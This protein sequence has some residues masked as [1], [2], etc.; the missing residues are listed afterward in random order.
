[1]AA[2]ATYWN[3]WWSWYVF[4]NVAT[5][6]IFDWILF[7]CAAFVQLIKMC[8]F[9]S[10]R[11]GHSMYEQH[12]KRHKFLSFIGFI[13]ALASFALISSNMY[14]CIYYEHVGGVVLIIYEAVQTIV[15]LPILHMLIINQEATGQRKQGMDYS[16]H[17]QESING[18]VSTT[19]QKTN[20][21]Y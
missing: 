20:Y 11:T 1:M 15:M 18:G 19:A 6:R 16:Y 7:G 14:L 2:D 17:E 9:C 4:H 5:V 12:S 10:H 13:V 21:M 8:N 3:Y